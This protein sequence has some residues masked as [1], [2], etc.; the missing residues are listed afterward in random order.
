MKSIRIADVSTRVSEIVDVIAA[1][2]LA[3]IPVRGAYRII[4]DA[5]SEAAITRLAQSKQR[6]HNRPALILV[7]DLKAA[8]DIVDG[9]TWS[10]TK[11][12]S[13]SLWPGPLTLLLPP[14]D[15]LPIKINRM[16]TRS[17]GSIGIR[18]PED[19]LTT[20]IVGQLG[21]PLVVSSANLENK[22]GSSSAATV[23]ARFAR[24]V[25]IWV[26]AMDIPPEP[27]S[28]LVEVTER[29]FK[30]IREG[31]VSHDAIERALA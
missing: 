24:T 10:T 27:P 25:A 11:R 17:T 26:D 21:G 19:P 18:V 4:A 13:K 15:R 8:H 22:P 2:D 30:I 28:T 29:G 20:A 5:R 16:L 7:G 1:G 9:T 31:A 6:A 3:C 23:R 14:S 12:L